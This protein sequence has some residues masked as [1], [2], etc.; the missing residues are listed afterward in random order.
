MINGIDIASY[1]PGVY[2]TTGL[3]FVFIKATEGT[4][5]VNPKMKQQA[6]TARTAG[7]VVG[8]YHFLHPGNIQAQAEYF[9]A[10]CASLEGDMLVCDWETT[11]TGGR[12]TCA[13]KDAFLRAVK[14]LRPGHRVGLY[15]NVDYWKHRD[16]TSYAADFLWIADPNNPKGRPGI[17]AKWLFHQWGQRTTDQDVAAF[18]SR[19]DLRHWCGYP[20]PPTKKPTPKPTPPP[21][22]PVPQTK[23]QQQ[24]ARLSRLEA[25]VD[26]LEKK[27]N[28]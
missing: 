5:Y 23:D 14:K 8:F 27:L 2:P 21:P 12:P 17:K 25:E 4:S 19:S 18:N 22:A 3:D 7:L 28:G 9:V 1:Q 13:E 10:R 24:D 11:A 26:V 20:A 6:A 15:C 16:T